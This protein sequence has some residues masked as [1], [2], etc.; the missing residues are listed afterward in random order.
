MDQDDEAVLKLTNSASQVLVKAC[1]I[2]PGLEQ[3]LMFALDIFVFSTM[4]FVVVCV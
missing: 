4:K 1:T 3:F 2:M